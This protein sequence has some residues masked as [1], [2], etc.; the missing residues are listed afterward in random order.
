[1]GSD[2]PTREEVVGKF[3]E[4][5]AV[6]ADVDTGTNTVVESTEIEIPSL[7]VKGTA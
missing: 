5:A 2:V 1:M 6:D 7:V 3:V 4:R